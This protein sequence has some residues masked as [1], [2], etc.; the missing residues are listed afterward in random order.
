MTSQPLDIA[1]ALKAFD[2]HIPNPGDYWEESI[3]DMSDL[4][5][6]EEDEGESGPCD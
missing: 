1:P 4:S 6:L 5:E 2:L 3:D